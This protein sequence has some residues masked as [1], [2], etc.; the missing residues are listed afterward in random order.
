MQAGISMGVEMPQFVYG[1]YRLKVEMHIARSAY[2][3]LNWLNRNFVV[4]S[5]YNI[6][7]RNKHRDR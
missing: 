1:E 4:H 7:I 2:Y 3:Q 5:K 6:R